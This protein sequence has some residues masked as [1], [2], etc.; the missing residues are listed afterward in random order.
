MKKM[1]GILWLNMLVISALAQTSV[2][3]TILNSVSK[4]PVSYASVV[5]N[6]GGGYTASEVG[7]VQLLTKNSTLKIKISAIGYATIDTNIAV[8]SN[9][10]LIIYLT[11]LQVLLQ[12]VEVNAIR[13]SEASPFTK[14][15]LSKAYIE[16]NNMGQDLPYLLNQIPNVTISS[17]AG[18]GIGYTAMRI[19]GTDATRINMTINGLPYNDAESQGIFFV[20]LPDFAS[21]TTS[22]QVQRG[23]GTS[24]NGAGAFGA[25]MNFSTNEYNPKS[26]IELNNSIGSFKSIKNTLKF[27]SGLIGKHFTIDGRV[28]NISS[29]GYVDRASSQ[30]QSGYLSAGYWGKKTAIRFNVL[31]GKEKTYQAWNGISQ[32]ALATN[33]TAN[34]SGTE[35]SGTPYENETD[36]YWQNHYQFF[37]NQQ[38]NNN[39]TINTAFFLTPGKGYYEQYKADQKLSKYGIAPFEIG[40]TPITKTDLVRR[41]WLDNDYFGQIFSIQ[42]KNE[43]TQFTLGGGWTKLNGN[44]FGQVIWS[45]ANPLVYNKYYS[46]TAYKNDANVY[47]KLQQRISK[48]LEAFAD[49]Q[50]RNV[51]YTINGFRNNPTINT[52]ATYNF[53]NPKIGISYKYQNWTGFVSYAQANKE[54][55]RD[56]F[57]AN[58]LQQPKSEQLHDIEVQAKRKAIFK[59]FDLGATFYYMQ[60]K[61]QLVLTGKINDVGAYTRTNIPNSYR[62]GVEVEA[63]YKFSNLT[64]AYSISLSKN[65]IKN[66][67][68]YIDNYDDGTQA[69]KLYTSTNIAFSPAVVQNLA[70]NYTP[71]TYLE[72][73]WM[74][75]HVGKQYLDNT[76]SNLRSLKAFVVNDLRASYTLPTQ[77]VKEAKIA[78][79]INN[80]L[81]VL[82]EPN[83]YTFGY[84]SGGNY[85]YE[86]YYYPSAGRNIM[87]ALNIKL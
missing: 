86:N 28:S 16:K 69:T 79:Q 30:L 39:W 43:Q 55:N 21:S 47:T 59:G 44:H 23:V 7:V 34:S 37:I 2:K 62:T 80:I 85:T 35:K 36:N 41:L 22:V 19:R 82:Y 24:S 51:I 77:W 14:T 61:N 78:V 84:I 76:T 32:T 25:S 38:L 56:D 71:L 74:A 58:T 64:M 81:N 66:F 73:S 33:R 40:A 4:Q 3:C 45:K 9:T 5:A 57:E 67:T 87:V 17:D 48:K 53:I 13:A 12:P 60:Y 54:P 75:K 65:K 83:G 29:N 11:P 50:Y 46:T 72:I 8:V 52:N 1:L 26:Y 27:G 63:N 42:Q 68:E 6:S 10:A 18:N 70:V 49:L 15:N 20:D 31:L